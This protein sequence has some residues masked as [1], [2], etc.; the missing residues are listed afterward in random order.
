[1]ASASLPMQSPAKTIGR[2]MMWASAR[3]TGLSESLGSRPFGRPKCESRITLPPLSAISV[4]VGAMRSRRVASETWPLSIGTLRSTRSKTRLP[5][6]SAWSSVRKDVIS[7]RSESTPQRWQRQRPTWR[8]GRREAESRSATAKVDLRYPR[9]DRRY[10]PAPLLSRQA[11]FPLSAM[12]LSRPSCLLREGALFKHG[13]L[14]IPAA[15]IYIVH[16]EIL[17]HLEQISLCLN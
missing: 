17:P 6:T 4:M 7:E 10:V 14:K 3:A 11:S 1:A 5:E 13:I 12:M 2:M 16:F 8:S 15:V 9:V